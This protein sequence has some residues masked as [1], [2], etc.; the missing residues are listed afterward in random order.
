MLEKNRI[1]AV[2]IVIAIFAGCASSAS[3]V[4]SEGCGDLTPLQDAGTAR[5]CVRH[6]LLPESYESAMLDRP[7]IEAKPVGSSSSIFVG[8]P[9]AKTYPVGPE[10]KKDLARLTEEIFAS[11]LS[12]LRLEQ[13]GAAGPGVL[14]V[15][16]RLLDVYFET[17]TDPESGAGYLL[18][19]R[20]RA[21]LVVELIDSRSDTLLLRA[22]GD[23]ATEPPGDAESQL[24]QLAFLWGALLVESIG[25]LRG[26]QAAA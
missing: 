7:R 1:L 21:T 20:A 23:R 9:P 6:A 22:Y 19:R 8:R 11:S 18:E 5:V 24:K 26:I 4:K 25:H 16:A 10:Q 2:P 12:D 14:L 3:R 15:R 13:A 17:P